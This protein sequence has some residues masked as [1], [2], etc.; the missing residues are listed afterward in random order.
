MP[1]PCFASTNVNR[2]FSKLDH[3]HSLIPCKFL[4]VFA[5]TESWVT[6]EIDDSLVSIENFIVHRD[7]RDDGRVGGGVA[8]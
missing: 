6:S 2:A 5:I 8:V 1:L 4:Q 7:D 3:I